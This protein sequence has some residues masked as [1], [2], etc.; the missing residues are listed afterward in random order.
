MLTKR[1]SLFL[2]LLFSFSL[3]AGE[4]PMTITPASGP[5]TGGTEVTITGDF[6]TWPYEVMFGQI[7]ATS[8][9][10]VDSRTLVA[11]TPAHLPGPSRITIFEYD[12][13]LFTPLIFQFTGDVPLEH[14]E[15]LLVPVHIEPVHGGFGSIFNTELYGAAKHAHVQLYGLKVDCG[16]A[17]PCFPMVDW[18]DTPVELS[19][20]EEKYIEPNGAPGRFAYVPRAQADD[21]ALTL[22]AFDVSRDQENYGTA[23]PVVRFDEAADT[24]IVFPAVPITPKFRNTLRIYSDVAMRVTID[25]AGMR[26][27]VELAPGADMFQPAFATWTNFPTGPAQHRVTITA[28]A[29]GNPPAYAGKIW[30]LLTITNNDTQD[31]MALWPQP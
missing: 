20:T 4:I 22:R 5:A 23:I 8:T 10:R 25:V 14:F 11:V 17:S 12:T 19:P 13:F 18:W 9:R 26:E 27:V 21:V 6:G 29:T 30:A 7:P 15:R 2:A 16:I 3:L 28:E 24:M 31:I 1:A